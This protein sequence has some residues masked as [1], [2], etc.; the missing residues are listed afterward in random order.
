LEVLLASMLMAVVLVPAL[1]LMRDALST[2]RE[3]E[4]RELLTTFCTSKIEEYLA[5]ISAYWQT[6]T[7]EGT[8]TA[9]GYSHLRYSV[10]CSDAVGDG[11][12][13]N[14]LMAIVVTTW[15]DVNGNGMRDTDESAVT[16]ASKVAKLMTYL[17]EVDG[18]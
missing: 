1:R 11:G 14:Q 8:F 17:D 3:L 16:L 13:T 4:Q 5:R 15:D 18:G 7:F 9:E 10:N 12:M 6:G 2:S